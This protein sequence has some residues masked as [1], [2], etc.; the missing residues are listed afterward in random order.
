MDIP[1]LETERLVLR[2][3]LTSDAPEVMRMAGDADIAATTL[4]IPHPYEPGMAETWIAS[5]Q[6]GFESGKVVNFA[7][8][9]R[10]DGALVGAIGLVLTAAHRRAELGYWVGKEHW[11]RGYATEAAGAVLRHGFEVLAL[12][13]IEAHH[14]SRNPASG[15]VMQKNGMQHEGRLAQHVLKNGVFEDLELYGLLRAGA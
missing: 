10:E 11:N 9:R 14:M 5:H 3:F 6:E 4:N 12:H 15:R 7:I 2:P 1:R 8:T 13:R